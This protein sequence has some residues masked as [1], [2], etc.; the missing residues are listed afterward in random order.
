M[1]GADRDLTL[2]EQLAGPFLRE[3]RPTGGLPLPA[4]QITSVVFYSKGGYSV[5]TVLGTEHFDKRWGA[6]PTSICEIAEGTH[7]SHLE[8][9]LPAAEVAT[10]FKVEVDVHWSVT[11]YLLVVRER[12]TDVAQR[13]SAPI[14]E[15]LRQVSER[16]EVRAAPEANRAVDAE[17]RGG[18]WDDLGHH[19]GLRA[20]LFVRFT[21]DEK[22]STQVDGR[23]D[24]SWED[25]QRRR[26]HDRE[27]AA[28]RRRVELLQMRMAAFRSMVEG[29]EWNQIAFM[30]ADKPEEARAFMELLRQ[31][32]RE[33]RRG[34]LDHTLRL[35]E[36]G[37]IQSPD[38][39]DQV[40]ELLK[41]SGFRVEGS[42]G[43]PPQRGS[44]SAPAALPTGKP[45]PDRPY[46]PYTPSWLDGEPDE[47]GGAGGAG[48][49][50]DLADDSTA[51]RD[52]PGPSRAAGQR[53]PPA[54]RS[55][56]FDD[57]DDDL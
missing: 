10:F 16:F 53:Q 40:R 9:E 11:D 45:H 57:W 39:E 31:E 42:L 4:A 52:A 20:R 18:R 27:V 50:A 22:T 12:V 32:A 25:E 3:Y 33:D 46:T 26:D 7:V 38:L 47:P 30:L 14:L 55:D 37:V 15:R 43:R 5:V 21:T 36:D 6:R 41:G 17:C 13:L 28:E 44:G 29:G 34:L 56:A 24:A 51:P 2:P 8:L 1:T 23:R 19:L 49:I 48:G 35:I 54:R